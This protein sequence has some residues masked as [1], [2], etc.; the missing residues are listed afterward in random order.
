MKYKLLIKQIRILKNMTQDDLAR[1]SQIK[2]AY[3]SQLENENNL[4]SPTLRTMFKIA[5][6][7]DYCPH[8]LIMYDVPCN[9]NCIA[10]CEHNIFFE[11]SDVIT[12]CCQP[13]TLYNSREVLDMNEKT[14]VYI[15]PTLKEKVRIELIKQGEKKSLSA[16]VNELLEQWMKEQ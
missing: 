7:L 6:A 15:E 13:H 11:H 5:T 9:K 2:Q 4:K 1:K 12:V 14:T 10:E 8:L 16:L 3:I